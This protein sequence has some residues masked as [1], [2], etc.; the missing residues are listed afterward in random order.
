MFH[1]NSR[2]FVVA[3]H[4]LFPYTTYIYIAITDPIP[5]PVMRIDPEKYE[6]KTHTHKNAKYIPVLCVK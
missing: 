1:K 6:E 5:D 2:D 4:D 3:P